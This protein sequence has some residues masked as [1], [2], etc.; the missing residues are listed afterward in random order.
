MHH[1]TLCRGIFGNLLIS[2]LCSY[3]FCHIKGRLYDKFGVNGGGNWSTQEKT[4]LN[5]KSLPSFS[6]ALSQILSQGRSEKISHKCLC[7]IPLY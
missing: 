5:P 1:A 4:L 2:G 6:H 3:F 7:L